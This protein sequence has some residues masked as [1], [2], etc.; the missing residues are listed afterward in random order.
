MD[1]L[2]QEIRQRFA[3]QLSAVR[4]VKHAVL[5]RKGDALDWIYFPLSAVISK[6]QTDDSGHA[7]EIAMT[8]RE[9]VVGLTSAFDNGVAMNTCQVF[10]GGTVL[11]M[12][13][14]FIRK[15]LEC[16]P[17]LNAAMMAHKSELLKQ[18]SRRVLCNRYHTV[19]QRL[20]TW[21]LL[22]A[23][24]TGRQSLSI[25]HADGARSLGVHRPTVTEAAI[26]LAE[27]GVSEQS[28]G[29]IRILDAGRL[30]AMACECFPDFSIDRAAAVV[31]TEDGRTAA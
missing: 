10:I 7:I 29:R 31:V 11:R 19:E 23:E 21:M 14:E 9:G 26:L 24:R 28:A 12:R 4:L 8:G 2:P 22:V 1:S 15:I 3:F 30:G 16:N 18:M 6:F 27:R 20:S 25:T 13:L 5:Y 17:E